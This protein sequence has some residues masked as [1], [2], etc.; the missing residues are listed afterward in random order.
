MAPSL[1]EGAVRKPPSLAE[2][3]VRMVPS[4]AAGVAV[5]EMGLEGVAEQTPALRTRSAGAGLRA[6]SEGRAWVVEA[7]V[8]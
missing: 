2:G 7:V 1:A 3:A 5:G 8:G 6:R 4:P